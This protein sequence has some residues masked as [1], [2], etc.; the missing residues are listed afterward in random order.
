[1]S[2]L[3]ELTVDFCREHIRYSYPEIYSCA[4]R[5]RVLVERKLYELLLIL[6]DSQTVLETSGNLQDS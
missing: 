2:N 1:M 6:E 4:S 3:A 5:K